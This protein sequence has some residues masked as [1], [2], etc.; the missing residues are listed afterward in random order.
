MNPNSLHAAPAPAPAH[1]VR[2]LLA[3][4][5]RV[6]AWVSHDLLALGARAAMAGVFLQSGR[7]KVEGLLSVTDAAVSLFED[8]YRL[9]L[10]PPDAAAHLA[11]YAEHAFP[12]LLV[13]VSTD[14]REA[15]F[16]N[17]QDWFG[18][19]PS[20]RQARVVSFDS[21]EDRFIPEAAHRLVDWAAPASSGL[22]LRPPPIR[23]L[24]VSNLLRVEH[25]SPTIH[26]VQS[27]ATGWSEIRDN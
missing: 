7:T 12:V 6:S 9:P 23:E 10:L 26:V 3:L 24:L 5:D 19:D 2:R 18:G 14:A 17:L 4:R 25:I 22:Y 1:R 8:E 27:T 11:A 15:W 16:K 13:L 20:R 21:A